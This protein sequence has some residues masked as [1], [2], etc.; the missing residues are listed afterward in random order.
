MIKLVIADNEYASR[1]D[2]AS[3]DWLMMSIRLVGLGINGADTLNIIRH[4]TPHILLTEV[5]LPGMDGIELTRI[6]K[7]EYPNTRIIFL[8]KYNEFDFA[9]SAI[10]LG[11]DGFLLKP[12][13]PKSIIDAVLK[14]KNVIEEEGKREQHVRDLER[15]IKE[16]QLLMQNNILAEGEQST[17][18][19]MIEQIIS[20]IEQH[21][22]ENITLS[23]MGSYVHLNPIYLSRLLKKVKGETFLEIL[24]RT[25]VTKAI[26]MLRDPAIKTCEVASRVGINDPKYFGQVFKKQYG[27]TLKEFRRDCGKQN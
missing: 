7:S 10:R 8:T 2:L 27:M 19:G 9:F 6:I 23:S 11:V 20:Y 16:I 1:K 22:S 26:E 24:T 21:Y 12:S 14:A 15:Q 3:I 4:T 5:R 18:N 25:R 13:D 17:K